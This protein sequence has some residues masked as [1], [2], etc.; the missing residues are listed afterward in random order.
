MAGATRYGLAVVNAGGGKQQ[1]QQGESIQ[2]IS[3]STCFMI[4]VISGVLL[5][6][7]LPLTGLCSYMA[8]HCFAEWQLTCLG[9]D[10]NM[11]GW[12]GFR[13]LQRARGTWSC[14][15]RNAVH[16]QWQ[17]VKSLTGTPCT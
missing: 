4:L 17:S 6:A 13:Y 7:K 1:Q 9:S 10:F 11:T 3:V 5:L 15:L 16:W 2:G 14:L 12:A 8:F